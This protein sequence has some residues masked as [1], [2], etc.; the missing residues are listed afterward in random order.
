MAVIATVSAKG[1]PGASTAALAFTL[2][3]GGR[4]ILAECDPAGGDILAGYLS[5]VE[6]PGGFGLLQVAKADLRNELAQEFWGHLIDLEDPHRQRLVLPG[7]T[8]PAQA[9]TLRPTW[10]GLAAFLADLEHAEPG[11]DV[12]ADCGRLA[13]ADTP[14]PVLARADLVLL[15]VR[16]SSLRE[17]AHVGPALTQLRRELSEASGRFGLLLIGDGPYRAREIERRFGTPVVATL[18]DDRRTAAALCGIDRLRGSRDLLRHA[19]SAER[20]VRDVVARRR[21]RHGTPV[22]AGHGQ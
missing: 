8:D 3:W 17:L 21:A 1:S 16:P 10:P 11:Y 19:A 22:E 6:I 13:G 20:A 2:S 9:A 5:G 18:P 15:V 4:T 12:I 14:W 7:I